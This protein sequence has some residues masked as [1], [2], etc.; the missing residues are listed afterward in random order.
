MKKITSFFKDRFEALTKSKFPKF[1]TKSWIFF[2]ISTP[3]CPILFVSMYFQEYTQVL[4]SHN[5]DVALSMLVLSSSIPAA[6]SLTAVFYTWYLFTK[7]VKMSSLEILKDVE[8]CIYN[9]PIIAIEVGIK[10]VESAG[11]VNYRSN[12]IEK[13]IFWENMK[14]YECMNELA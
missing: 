13:Q 9:V 7:L 11:K 3:L 4:Q 6:V 8:V 14:W 2:H 5:L 12:R 1:S 10:I